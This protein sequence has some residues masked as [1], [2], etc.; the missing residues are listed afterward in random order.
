MR[1]KKGWAAVLLGVSML[2]VPTG[3]YAEESMEVQMINAWDEETGTSTQDDI[4][5]NSSCEIE[6]YGT[7]LATS[8]EFVD[9]LAK[10]NAGKGGAYDVGNMKS[11]N[12]AEYA[13]L[14][15]DLTNITT[16][17]KNFLEQCEV[18]VV[19]NE[20]YEY[21]GWQYQYDY[22]NTTD[23]DYNINAVIH[24][25]DQFAIGPM[26]QGHYCF[27]CTLPNSVVTSKEPLQMVITIDGHE[28][29]YNIRK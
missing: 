6:N 28:I 22:D 12:D 10:F 1:N 21:Q 17:D 23:Y 9:V 11:G 26:Y 29:I 25:D 5:I 14:K 4:K 18:K 8:F 20:K 2:Q 16:A 19:F 7:F 3:V 27:G 15:V 13:V 24:Q